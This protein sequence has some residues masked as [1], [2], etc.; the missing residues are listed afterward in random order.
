MK[1]DGKLIAQQ[2]LE[3]LK[4]KIQQSHLSPTLAVILVGENP[5]SASYIKQKEKA[6]C[7][8]G[9]KLIVKNLPEKTS[10]EKLIKLIG[11]TNKNDQIDGIIVQLPL[12][13]RSLGE[14]GPEHLDSEKILAH[15]APA[16]D[17]DGF[18]P[19]SQFRPPVALAVLKVLEEIQKPKDTSD[20]VL[21]LPKDSSEVDG[22]RW[23][24]SKFLV[25]GRGLTAG[26]PIAETLRQNGYQVSIAHSQTS[27]DQLVNLVKSADVIISCVGKANVIKASQIKKGAIIIGVGIHREL[28]HL[29]G[30]NPAERR[31]GVPAAGGGDTSE[32]NVLKW[33]LVGD[34]NEEEMSKV[35]SF[36]TPT[37]GGLGPINVACLMENL[38]Q[39]A[40]KFD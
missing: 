37:P 23:R 2:I 36:Y 7:L 25:I 30:E 3:N 11:E 35:A 18:H 40:Q 26:K 14:G 4:K 5:A 16:K 10:A 6:A 21:S 22:N 34:F 38:V 13:S 15:I 17:V 28:T 33:K 29:R 27:P 9:A 24:N 20:G 12:P 31:D 19:D 32:V 39:A 8:I 1:I